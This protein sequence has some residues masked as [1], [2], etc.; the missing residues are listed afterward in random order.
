MSTPETPLP[1]RIPITTLWSKGYRTL[2]AIKKPL[3]HISI[4]GGFLPFALSYIVG[5]IWGIELVSTYMS[6]DGISFTN[7]FA[8][9]PFIAEHS[10]MLLMLTLLEILPYLFATISCFAV[11]HL[12]RLYYEGRPIP[13]A[14]SCLGAALK[15]RILIGGIFI[16]AALAMAEIIYTT[17]PVLAL[18][19]TLSVF[20]FVV[21][22]CDGTSLWKSLGQSFLLKHGGGIR[23]GRSILLVQHLISGF[24]LGVLIL[25]ILW[26]SETLIHLGAYVRTYALIQLGVASVDEWFVVILSALKQWGVVGSFLLFIVVLITTK[27]WF[28]AHIRISAFQ[29]TKA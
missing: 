10:G 25:F 1:R 7:N 27:Y 22:A 26:M 21:Q 16:M 2:K 14:L 15:Y 9:L 23:G 8:L 12:C 13:N 28:D 5:T 4:F 11:M 20:S 17:S 6:E 24:A 18:I 19:L 29:Q 3:F